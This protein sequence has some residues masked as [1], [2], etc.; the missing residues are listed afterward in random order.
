MVGKLHSFIFLSVVFVLLI[1]L[2]IAMMGDTY[3]KIAEI[4]NEWMRQWARTVLIVERGIPP[5]ERLRQQDLYSERMATG[6]KAMVMKQTMSEDQLEEIKDIIEMKVNHR[7]NIN[8]RKT[9]FGHESNS[10][11]GLD[12]AAASVIAPDV[13]QDDNEEEII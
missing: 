4:K 1:N 12:L 10:L 2:L 13:A 3:T 5:K 7:R 11:I 9:K 6:E 8:R